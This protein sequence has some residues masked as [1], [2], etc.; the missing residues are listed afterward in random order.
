M[1]VDSELD[2][3]GHT[4]DEA[5]TKL[6]KYIYQSYMGGMIAVRI[7]HGY[8]TGTLRRAVQKELKCNS[9]VNTIRSGG[10]GEGGEGVTIAELADH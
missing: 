2:L 1:I 5:L 10:Y 6:N 3:H 4:V 8:G 9:L 7:N